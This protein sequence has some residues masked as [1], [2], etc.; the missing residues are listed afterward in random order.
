MTVSFNVTEMLAFLAP[1]S[2]SEKAKRT[3]SVF[4]W[5]M[6]RAAE[7][8]AI[9]MSGIERTFVGRWRTRRMDFD[10]EVERRG[11]P[12]YTT[13]RSLVALHPAH[14]W[15]YIRPRPPPPLARKAFHQRGDRRRPGKQKPM[16]ASLAKSDRLVPT[17]TKTKVV[18]SREMN[19]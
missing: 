19:S 17:R 9:Y 4:P 18:K 15:P 11:R 5:A 3:P 13:P 2:L 10:S 16:G 8:P 14:R 1:T 7:V 6:L 12:R